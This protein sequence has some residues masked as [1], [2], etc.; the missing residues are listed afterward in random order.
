M[1]FGLAI[2]LAVLW[3]LAEFL[4]ISSLGHMT[5]L[6]TWFGLGVEGPAWSLLLHAGALLAVIAAYPKRLWAMITHPLVSELKWLILS[7][8]PTVAVAYTIGPNIEAAYK[9]SWLGPCFLATSLI[10]LIGEGIGTLWKNRSGHV[11]WYHAL[12]MGAAQA[13]ALLPG[14]TRAGFALAGGL[15]TGLKRKR[16]ADFGFAMAI[17]AMIWAVARDCQAIS[18]GAAEAGAEFFAHLGREIGEL[19]VSPALPVLAS[20]AA[21]FLAIKLIVS[22]LKKG[23]LKWCVVYACLLGLAVIAWQL[24]QG[25]K[26]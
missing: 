14:F 20:A 13:F 23:S 6:Q 7:I 24:M 9:D 16:A 8:A 11:T 15:A 1:E 12:A 22:A 17:P 3:G 21:G 19:G 4:P 5:L 10:L 26:L 25:A 2:G 18:R